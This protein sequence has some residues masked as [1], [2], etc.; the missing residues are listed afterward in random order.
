MIAVTDV[1]NFE[2]HNANETMYDVPLHYQES[3]L[4]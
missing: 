4:T 2:L 3:V 1:P